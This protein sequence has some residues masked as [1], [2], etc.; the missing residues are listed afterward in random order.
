MYRWKAAH[1]EHAKVRGHLACG[2]FRMTLTHAS[3]ANRFM[4]GQVSQSQQLQT[5]RKR[6]TLTLFP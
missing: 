6:L 1:N 3:P 2:E 5:T 4:D